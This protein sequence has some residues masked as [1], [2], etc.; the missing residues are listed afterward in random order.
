MNIN[1]HTEHVISVVVGLSV[2]LTTTLYQTYLLNGLMISVTR[3]PLTMN[4]IA[5]KIERG[6]L[7][8]MF[9]DRDSS[10]RNIIHRSANY[11]SRGSIEHLSDALKITNPL[12][13][14]DYENDKNFLQTLRTHRAIYISN[15]GNIKSLTH[16]HAMCVRRV[17]TYI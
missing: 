1:T 8:V 7:T 6:H 10:I 11:T 16:T 3:M 4:E 2:L 5:D 15:M 17:A 9:H 14:T 13:Y 12:Y